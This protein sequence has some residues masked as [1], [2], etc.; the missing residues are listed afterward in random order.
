MLSKGQ[1]SIS[2]SGSDF[3]IKDVQNVTQCLQRMS[4]SFFKEIIPYFQPFIIMVNFIPPPPP[5]NIDKFS[6]YN[7]SNEQGQS[8][9]KNTCLNSSYKLFYT[10]T[11][12]L[13]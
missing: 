7:T 9:K 1:K 4:L 12:T 3:E 6:Q 5:Q 11:F 10:S 8:K 2:V 13:F